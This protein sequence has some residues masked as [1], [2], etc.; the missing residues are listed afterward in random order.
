MISLAR[1][2]TAAARVVEPCDTLR[3][4]CDDSTSWRTANDQSHQQCFPRSGQCAGARTSANPE[5]HE[6]DCAADRGTIQRRAASP[7]NDASVRRT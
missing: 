6:A 7:K 5:T 2:R 3:S 4:T 1:P